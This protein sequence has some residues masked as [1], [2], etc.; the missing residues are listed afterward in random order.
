MPALASEAVLIGKEG[1]TLAS[2]LQRGASVL[3]IVA[4]KLD[5]VQLGSVN[6]IDVRGNGAVWVCT[7]AGDLIL[8]AESEIATSGGLR[9]A[10]D[11]LALRDGTSIGRMSG[12]WPSIEAYGG[13]G[14]ARAGAQVSM[15]LEHLRATGEMEG[16]SSHVIR[17]GSLSRDSVKE[18]GSLL[19][20]GQCEMEP[21]PVG[22]S[23]LRKV[24]GKPSKA[25]TASAE[26]VYRALLALWQ[27]GGDEGLFRLPVELTRLRWLSLA[28][29]A[30]LGT[31]YALDYR[32]R[33]WPIEV[34]LS[35]VTEHQ[36]HASVQIVLPVKAERLV[37]LEAAASGCYII[38]NNLVCSA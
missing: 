31:P 23:W 5:F 18:T 33:Y 6:L 32:P 28:V 15:L 38:A 1:P 12:E 26:G 20:G 13:A 19:V 16:A 8:G 37:D 22:W 3:G 7:D 4:G 2:S 10:G 34:E 11:L 27:A 25:P 29:L 21:G 14:E 9:T 17:V 36:H 30:E 24:S 35:P